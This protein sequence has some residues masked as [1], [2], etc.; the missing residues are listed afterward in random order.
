MAVVF[1]FVGHEHWA[2][3]RV[4]AFSCLASISPGP[5]HDEAGRRSSQTDFLL[6][7]AVLQRKRQQNM[8][9]KAIREYY[10]KQLLSRWLPEY[11]GGKHTIE[12]KQVRE[13]SAMEG[14]G[15]VLINRLGPFV[16]SGGFAVVG[17]G[18]DTPVEG[19]GT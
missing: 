16:E 8:S 2:A 1:R 18:L 5:S 7:P 6:L 3:K 11:S 14:R 17:T 13:A 4:S 9:A 12:G 10:G 15:V 19:R